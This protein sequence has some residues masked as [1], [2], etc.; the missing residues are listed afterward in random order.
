MSLSVRSIF[1]QTL[2]PCEVII[3]DDGSGQD[4]ERAVEALSKESPVPI[5]HI[6]QEDKGFR[7]STIRNKA[8]AA[9][10]ADYII[11]VDGDCILERHFVEDHMAVAEAGHFVCGGRVRLGKNE[12]QKILGG[13]PLSA[14]AP[15]RIWPTHPQFLNSLRIAPLRQLLAKRYGDV[16]EHVHGCNM[17]FWRA[18]LI[19]VN[20]YNEEFTGW[21][22]EDLELAWRLNFAGVERKSLKFGGVCYHIYHPESPHDKADANAKLLCET[23][24]A[25]APRCANGIDKYLGK[26]SADKGADV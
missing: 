11:Q 4:T 26:A 22:H 6:W 10:E 20:G 5:K 16:G 13:S 24:A 14:Y 9:A 17:A 23:I 15:P 21:G 25:G 18:D 2:L 7:L 3:A 1:R 12:S 8:I 19:R